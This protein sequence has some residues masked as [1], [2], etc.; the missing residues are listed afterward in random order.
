MRGTDYEGFILIENDM[1]INLEREVRVTSL[2]NTK[3][4]IAVEQNYIHT[5][6]G[7]DKNR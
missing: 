3:I 5:A 1:D 2:E 4:V 6:I 7:G